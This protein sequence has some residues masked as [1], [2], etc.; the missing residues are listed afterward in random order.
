M[1]YEKKR[2]LK[3]SFKQVM[4]FLVAAALYFTLFLLFPV[5]L[6]LGAGLISGY[7]ARW[8]EGGAQTAALALAQLSR[9]QVSPSHALCGAFAVFSAA[10][11]VAKR[12]VRSVASWRQLTVLI[13][14][15]MIS[16]F[17]LSVM[18][19]KVNGVPMRVFIGV[20]TDLLGS[21]VL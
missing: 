10:L 3:I 17:T 20:L 11:S 18:L 4:L 6:V 9:A 14:Y 21:G 13:V 16:G 12:R 8:L 5:V 7:I 1:Q 2:K 15:A 19:C